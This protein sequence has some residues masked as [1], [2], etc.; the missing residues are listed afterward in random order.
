[1]ILSCSA[2]SVSVNAQQETSANELYRE[3]KKQDSLLFN[4]FNT[5]DTALFKSM[6]SEDLEFFHDLGGLTGYNHTVDFMRSVAT[7][8]ND[9]RR[10]LLSSSLEIY[11]VP[12]YGA[13]QKGAHAFCHTENGK[14]VCGTYQFIHIWKKTGDSWRITRVVSFGH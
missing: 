1:M 9:L 14:Q 12:G 13:I 5:R 10:E 6:F 8:K 7:G 11:P 3:I 4:A 2:A